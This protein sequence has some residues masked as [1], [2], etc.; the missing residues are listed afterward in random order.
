ME[1]GHI[2]ILL[3]LIQSAD[4]SI[5]DFLNGFAGNYFLDRMAGL[6]E[7]T[8]LLKGGLF[9]AV[10]WHLWFRS[11]PDREKRRAAIIVILIGVMLALVVARTIAKVDPIVKT[12][13]CPQ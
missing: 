8:N 11:G 3:H 6:T 2:H 13:F 4:L 10:Y 9:L 1:V 5:Y 12:I 7:S